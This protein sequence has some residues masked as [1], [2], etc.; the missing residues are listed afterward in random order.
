MSSSEPLR[1]G[2][3]VVHHTMQLDHAYPTGAEE[4]A[5]PACG[6]RFVVTWRPFEKTILDP[7]DVEAWHTGYQ[8][9]HPTNPSPTVDDRLAPWLRW[10]DQAGI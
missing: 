6:R 7:G 3:G 9:Q 5:C 10:F 1:G 2:G 4:W 8:D